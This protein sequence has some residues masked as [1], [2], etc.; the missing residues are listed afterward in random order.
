MSF[1]DSN[2]AREQVR[3]A[4]DIVDLVGSSLTLRRQ[5][6]I[7]LGL[8]PW[9]EDSRPSLQ[10]NPDRQSWKC[11]VCNI[12][13]DIFSFTMQREGIDFRQ[14]LEL[15]ADQAGIPL[16]RQAAQQQFQPG[17]PR[18]TRNLYQAMAWAEQQYHDYLVNSPDAEG[19]RRYLQERDITSESIQHHHLGYA[20]D[21]WQWLLN[22]SHSTPHSAAILEGI[23]AVATSESGRAY[24]R[25]KGRVIFPIRDTQTRPIAFGGRILPEHATER[26]A[27]YINSPETLLFSKSDQLYALDLARQ[28]ATKQNSLMVMEGYTDVIMA[29]QHGITNTVAVLGTALG[30]RHVQL[31]KRFADKIIL[32]LDGDD[33][34][35]RRTNEILELFIAAEVDLR[36]LT[37]P[38]GMDPCDFLNTQGKEVFLEKAAGAA[39]A[40]EHKVSTVLQGVDTVTDTHRAHQALEEILRTLAQA[41][42]SQPARSE[43]GRLLEQQVISRLARRFALG[44]EILRTRM[45]EIRSRQQDRRPTP[46]YDSDTQAPRPATWK[47]L[48]P[49]ETELLEILILSPELVSSALERIHVGIL[50][51][52]TGRALYT[53]YARIA[54]TGRLPDFGYV[55][56][57]MEDPQLKNILV[58]TDETAN[59]KAKHAE[60]QTAERLDELVKGFHSEALRTAGREQLAAL[61]NNTLDIEEEKELLQKLID[62]E[63]QRQGMSAPTD[64]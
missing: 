61:E 63:R 25:F 60:V 49:R 44:E 38:D 24:D 64:G 34:G 29:H 19:A 52:E 11:W 31:L 5:G 3:Q 13:G 62:Q 40:L 47:P 27:K 51:T 23:G 16:T 14:A 37:L 54:A 36:V 20:P 45:S 55:M 26:S 48:D 42:R 41:G 30:P 43:S 10:V 46:Q 6:R 15:L 4:I 33:A 9:H 8:C 57:E 58:E 35:Q 28:A 50:P 1:A 2:D 12:G 59:A 56:A 39:D 17:D 7:Y 21:Q 22:Q 18:D 53:L 32:I